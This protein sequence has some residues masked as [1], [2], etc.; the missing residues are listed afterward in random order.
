VPASERGKGE[1][2]AA[3][4]FDRERG[5]D[6][7]IERGRL[8]LRRSSVRIEGNQG[9]SIYLSDLE[10]GWGKKGLLLTGGGDLLVEGSEWW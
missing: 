8:Y 6:E 3:G 4:D 5:R 2:G 7:K 9:E 1:T 10:T